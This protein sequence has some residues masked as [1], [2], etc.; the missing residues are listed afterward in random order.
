[1]I[2][3]FIKLWSFWSLAMPM[4]YSSQI[5]IMHLLVKPQ[6]HKGLS[7]RKV[8]KIPSLATMQTRYFLR[9]QKHKRQ[10]ANRIFELTG[11]KMLNQLQNQDTS[12]YTP[13]P[14]IC[15]SLPLGSILTV[16]YSLLALQPP[17]S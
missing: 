4:I 1:M 9:T 15:F 3:A 11:A 6:E 8:E 12:H 10:K 16:Y 5:C 17:E 7:M 2:K 13:M 14:E